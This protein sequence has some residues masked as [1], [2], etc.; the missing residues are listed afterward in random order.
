MA[1]EQLQRHLMS[2]VTAKKVNRA[3]AQKRSEHIESSHRK[4]VEGDSKDRIWRLSETGRYDRFRI[5][6]QD[7]RIKRCR[8]FESSE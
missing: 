5:V 6:S 8:P 3:I 4:M 2:M 1:S 7:E